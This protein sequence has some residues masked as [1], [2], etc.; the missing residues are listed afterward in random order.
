MF[1][2]IT[3]ALLLAG[4]YS[5]AQDQAPTPSVEK[6]VFGVQTGLIGLWINHELKLSNRWALRSEIGSEL[7]AYSNKVND[8]VKR[9]M[10]PVVSVEPKWYYNLNRRARKDRNISKNSGNSISLKINYLPGW[11]GVG[12]DGIPKSNHLSI[13]PKWGI[14]RVYGK[15]F[16]FET[17]LG[18]GP[19][20]YVGN[21]PRW[22]KSESYIDLSVRIGYTF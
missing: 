16:T 18:V 22:D 4:V 6:S 10:C 19:Q 13:L 7:F 20:F 11:F 9:A 14:R 3:L 12:D 21:D 17:G 15:H 8:D 2:K 5:H 1:K